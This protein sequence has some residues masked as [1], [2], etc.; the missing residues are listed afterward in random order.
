MFDGGAFDLL[1]FRKT[2]AQTPKRLPL[3]LARREH[4]IRRH[5]V[6]NGRGKRVRHNIL[7]PR[8]RAACCLDQRVPRRGRGCWLACL[9]NV[10]EHKLHAD[11]RDQLEGRD[12]S[13]GRALHM[14]EELHRIRRFGHCRE[15]RDAFD[16][17]CEQLQHRSSDDAQR[18][19]RADEKLLQVIAGIVLPQWAGKI[20]HAPVCQHD[21]QT[22]HEIAHAA[23]AQHIYAAGIGRDV[24]AD[25]ATSFGREAQWEISSRFI[26]RAL[27]FGKDHAGFCRGRQAFDIHAANAVHA[28]ET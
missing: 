14:I 19:F 11:A 1:R 4:G 16:R 18:A 15:T 23:V 10:R 5:A 7:Q 27:K 3:C 2:L 8:V 24:A 6:R 25:R 17:F 20:E 22:K 9:R 26:G 28:G 21:F 13:A 12:E